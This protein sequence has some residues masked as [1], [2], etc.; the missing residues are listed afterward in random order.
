[1]E[2]EGYTTEDANKPTEFLVAS[3]DCFAA[4]AMTD[5]VLQVHRSRHYEFLA[6]LFA[7]TRSRP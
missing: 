4:L 7:T 3:V 1:M 5:G 6:L 2:T